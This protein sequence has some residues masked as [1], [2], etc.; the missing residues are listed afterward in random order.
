[1]T[2]NEAKKI[3]DRRLKDRFGID[4]AGFRIITRMLLVNTFNLDFRTKTKQAVIKLASAVIGFV[5]FVAISFGFFFFASKF[6][7]FSILAFVPESVP[8]IIAMAVFFI[9]FVP[10]LL[11]LTRT[12]YWSPDNKLMITFPCNGNTVF[13]ARMFVFFVGQYLKM[14]LIEVSFL[15]GYMIFA[16]FPWFMFIWALFGWM[17]LTL[18][19]VLFLSLASVP[20]YYVGLYLKRH[21]IVKIVLSGLFFIALVAVVAF[22]INLLPDEVNLFSSWGPY[23]AKIQKVLIFYQTELSFLLN[24]TT[25]AIGSNSG[26]GVVVF[27]RG[28]WL[29]L[30]IMIGIVIVCFFLVVYLINPLYFRLASFSNDL[31]EGNEKNW[32]KLHVYP[33]WLAQIFK[34]AL[35]FFKDPNI[36][37]GL[38]GTFV[39]LPI[40]ISLIDK[41]FGA[42]TTNIRG[43]MMVLSINVLLVLMVALSSNT[44][45]ARIFSEEGDAFVLTRSYPRNQVFMLSTKLLFP[46]LMG[47][48]SLALSVYFFASMKG[49]GV[50]SASL[51]GFAVVSLYLGH[52]L[53]AAGLDFTTK[54][55][56]FASGDFMSEG[57]N[58]VIVIGIF[59]AIL[60]AVLYYLFLQD[61]SSWW[62]L[63][64]E[65]TASLKLMLMSLGFLLVNLL[66]F[67][68]KIQLIY[69]EGQVQ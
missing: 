13:A 45:I 65:E 35:L 12:L 38:F 27:T 19:E 47:T 37:S 43:D 66:L 34:E 69:M 32:K 24:L 59:V 11:S 40:Y 23:F 2:G 1:M 53:F 56:H 36:F 52:L 58:R 4:W 6:N 29:A 61:F 16:R 28:S 39:F 22:L 8:S 10:A 25:M 57:E 55:D 9:G 60:A 42:M 17:I 62:R 67:Y 49:L 31:S 64:R 15:F 54:K 41:V 44:V 14:L 51:L 7:I 30:A 20:A 50:G 26:F 33:Y 21:S 46:A 48:F 5:A 68:R 63:T 18:A 3:K